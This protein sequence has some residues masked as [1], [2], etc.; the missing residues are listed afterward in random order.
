[1]TKASASPNLG[2]WAKADPKNRE[3][4]LWILTN[5]QL[6]DAVMLAR[7]P[8]AEFARVDDSWNLDNAA[9][10][11]WKKIYYA[12]P[13]SRTG[14][15]LR[16]AVACALRPPGSANRGAG[17]AAEQSSVFD[18]YMYYRK[19]HAAGELFPSFDT[20]T[21]WEMTH[22]VSASVSNADLDWGREALNTW[23]PGFRENENVVAMVGQ[24]WRRDPNGVPY[25]DMSCVMG[26]GGKCGPRSAFGVFI[27]QA[28]GI[29]AI[30]VGQ[31]AHAAITFRGRDGEWHMAQ[32]RGFKYPK[33]LTG[34]R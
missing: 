19:A 6:M 25:R 20:L 5:P 32:G 15:Y 18:R 34:T 23:M 33:S 16:L 10:E 30:G 13:A 17:D 24:V 1:M 11:N 29:P 2:A 26:A 3:F 12:D 9:L 4:L 14:V 27:N 22:V 21:I 28:F 7:T 31:P 8:T